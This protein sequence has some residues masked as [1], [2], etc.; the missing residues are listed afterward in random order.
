MAGRTLYEAD[1]FVFVTA[2]KHDELVIHQTG[3]QVRA[4]EGRV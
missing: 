1:W 3:G 2:G 4:A